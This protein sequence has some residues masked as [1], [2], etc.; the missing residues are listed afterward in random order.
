M[1]MAREASRVG[2][3]GYV[4]KI[5]ASTEL[6]TAIRALDEGHFFVSEQLRVRGG[7]TNRSSH[8]NEPS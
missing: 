7:L 4:S 5:D 8:S 3:R 1:Q 2:G 6:L